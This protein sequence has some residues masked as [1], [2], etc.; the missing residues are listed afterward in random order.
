MAQDHGGDAVP[1]V[2]QGED[3]LGAGLG[4]LVFGGHE[5]AAQLHHVREV[6][7][8]ELLRVVE[9]VGGRDVRLAVCL[10]LDVGAEDIAVAAQDGVR[11]GVPDDQLLV[12]MGGIHVE[13]VQVDGA[14][15]AAAAVAER[16]L[17]QAAD[18]LQHVGGVV[19]VD[20]VDLVVG[21]VG[22][23]QFPVGRELGQEQL[24]AYRVNNLFVHLGQS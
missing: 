23:A 4:A 21:L 2:V 5:R 1:E 15:R 9:H 6:V 18:L 16:D 3:R 17:A 8:D 20:H 24:P 12:G 13:L 22:V 10:E 19:A 7:L 14:A 11:L